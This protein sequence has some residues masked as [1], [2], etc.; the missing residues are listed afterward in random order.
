LRQAT[1]AAASCVPLDAQQQRERDDIS[2]ASM[3]VA[4][5]LRRLPASRL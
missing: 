1:T 4:C 3:V 5:V 2:V